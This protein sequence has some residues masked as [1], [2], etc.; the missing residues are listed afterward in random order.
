[1]KLTLMILD[2]LL[3]SACSNR[4]IY[5]SLQANRRYECMKLPPVQYQQCM[6]DANK[7]FDQY[8][9]ERKEATR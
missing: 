2:L 4:G 6:K 9:L 5:E 8:E 1:M 7:S 3:I